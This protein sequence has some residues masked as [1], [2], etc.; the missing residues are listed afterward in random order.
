MGIQNRDIAFDWDTCIVQPSDM[1]TPISEDKELSLAGIF[2]WAYELCSSPKNDATGYLSSYNEYISRDGLSSEGMTSYLPRIFGLHLA[3]QSLRRS[4][5]THSPFEAQSK[6]VQDHLAVFQ[7]SITTW[8][9]LPWITGYSIFQLCLLQILFCDG[10]PQKQRVSQ[11]SQSL[12]FAGMVLSVISTKFSGLHPH[13][14]LLNKVLA[15]ITSSDTASQHDVDFL[16]GGDLHEFCRDALRCVDM[17]IS[18]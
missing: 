6:L 17:G 18:H 13:R 2:S 9:A 4:T 8:L 12:S 15:Q 16:E 7:N 14:V 1:F 11:I 10:L 3:T 5:G